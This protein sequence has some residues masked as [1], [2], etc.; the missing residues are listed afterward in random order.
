M[1]WRDK[2]N[3]IMDLKQKIHW[4]YKFGIGK[5]DPESYVLEYISNPIRS[6]L[7]ENTFKKI[8]DKTQVNMSYDDW[9]E[10]KETEILG[11]GLRDKEKEIM[12]I[13]PKVNLKKYNILSSSLDKLVVI[14]TK[15]GLVI[16]GTVKGLR[17]C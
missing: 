4:D 1:N 13:F 11:E 9:E 8:V 15:S 6:S 5:T 10:G 14:K 12:T 7:F 2:L 17:K 3:N 16:K